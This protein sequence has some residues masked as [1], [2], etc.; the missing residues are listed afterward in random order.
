MSLILITCNIV[1]FYQVALMLLLLL[2][3]LSSPSNL[4]NQ[5]IPRSEALLSSTLNP[6][7]PVFTQIKSQDPIA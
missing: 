3:I 6:W 7:S 2:N 1:N 5:Y 4:M